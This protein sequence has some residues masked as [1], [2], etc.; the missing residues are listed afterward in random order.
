MMAETTAE[1]AA[2]YP[3]Q[4]FQIGISDTNRN[5]NAE[6]SFV[7]SAVQNG[8]SAENWTLNFVSSGVFEIVSS[9]NGQVLTSNGSD[10]ALANDSDGA[11]QRWKIEGVDKDY[12]G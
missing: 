4:R 9:A 7:K 6:D 10:V 1:A 8:T 11:N 2:S 3:V 5:V 12:D